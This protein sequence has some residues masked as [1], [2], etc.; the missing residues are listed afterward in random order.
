MWVYG[1]LV[2]ETTE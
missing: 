1:D 2:W